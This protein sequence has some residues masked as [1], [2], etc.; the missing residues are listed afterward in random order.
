MEVDGMPGMLEALG[1]CTVPACVRGHVVA[2]LQLHLRGHWH[3]VH[4]VGAD[5][6]PVL[7]ARM[8]VWHDGIHH[9]GIQ[10]AAH[11]AALRRIDLG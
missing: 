8:P 2:L 4:H 5:W 1:D 6:L 11:G 9:E 10:H 7:H 3:R